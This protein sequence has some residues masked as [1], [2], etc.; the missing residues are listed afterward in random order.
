MILAVKTNNETTE[1]HLLDKKGKLLTKKT[2]QPERKLADELLPEIES[3]IAM[4]SSGLTR[5]S[6]NKNLDSRIQSTEQVGARLRKSEN[7]NVSNRPFD[8]L[9]KLI[10]FTGPGSFT[11]LRIGITVMNTLAYSLD[12]PIVGTNNNRHSRDRAERGV[13]PD[14][15]RGNETLGI[16]D[17]DDLWLTDGL[18]RLRENENDRIVIPQYGAEP[19]ITSSRK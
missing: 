17:N 7:D 2:W 9:T 14:L 5:G 8:Q 12:I 18:K 10:V 1:I 6:S 4:S 16:Q 13:T 15:I 11:G 19:N 3:I